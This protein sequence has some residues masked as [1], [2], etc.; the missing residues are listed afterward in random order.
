MDEIDQKL[1]AKLR[2]NARLPAAELARDLGLSRTT[3]QSRIDR[4]ERSGVVTGY[5]VRL[6]EA[7][8]RGLIRAY[9]MLTVGPKQAASVVAAARRMPAVRRLQSVSGPFDLIAEAATESAAE[10]DALI[11][12]LGALEGVERTTSSIVLSSKIDR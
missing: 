2:E 10:M 3:V 7:H 8:E 4:L 1:L 9:V 12:A 5:T 11:D 6:S